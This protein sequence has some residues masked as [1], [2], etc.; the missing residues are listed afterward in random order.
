MHD[1][2]VTASWLLA[3]TERL[4]VGHLVLCDAFRH[5]AVLARQ[6]VTL[7]RASGGRFELGIGWGSVPSELEQ[8]GVMTT[9]A[10]SRVAR[11]GETLELIRALW[12][13]E[14][15]TYRGEFHK[16]EGGQQRP[17]P[18]SRIPIVIGGVGPKTLALVAKH[19]DWW[20]CPTH[21]LHRFD[22]MRDRVGSARIS[23]QEQVCFI[24][25]EDERSD[26]TAT[27]M[28]RFATPTDKP[29]VGN[30]E[31]LTGHF[32]ARI[33]KGIER[34]YIWF[35]DFAPPATLAAF[36]RNVIGALGAAADG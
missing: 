21:R 20:N 13:G 4:K 31:E 32:E 18:G 35:T 8:F 15:V 28:R 10:K 16:V 19:A 25:S 12:T 6:A 3:H 9:D 22:E 24:A 33:A 36:G 34:F 29:V 26:I 23:I 27:A 1:A 2:I 14:P 11:L 30:A 5:P 17:T 7:D